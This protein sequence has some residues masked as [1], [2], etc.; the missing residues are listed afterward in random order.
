MKI[1]PVKLRNKKASIP[2]L[3]DDKDFKTL[4]V[5]SWFTVSGGYAAQ[6]RE[7]RCRIAHR[8]LLD[9]ISK[10]NYIDHID[11]NPLNNQRSNLRV[12]S[13]AQN[14]QNQKKHSN[15]TSG[16]K[17]VVWVSK[18]KSWRVRVTE[19]RKVHQIGY[20]KDFEEAKK[21]RL[22]AIEKLHGAFQR[23]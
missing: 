13:P 4:N 2:M 21:A 9:S 23:V 3:V 7:G 6:M 11:G 19:N 12:C 1:I 20:F 10:Q 5:G 14:S 16:E 15:N 8:I 22:G 18:L 17:N